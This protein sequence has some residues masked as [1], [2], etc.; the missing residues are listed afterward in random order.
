THDTRP[1]YHLLAEDALHLTR[2][3]GFDADLR[4]D[5]LPRGQVLIIA[6]PN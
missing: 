1:P 4:P 3:S 5:R 2:A 6:R